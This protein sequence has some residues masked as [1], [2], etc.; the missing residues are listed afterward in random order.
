[1]ANISSSLYIL[2]ETFFTESSSNITRFPFRRFFLRQ[3]PVWASFMASM[4][5]KLQCYKKDSN[6]S[7][8]LAA[9]EFVIVFLGSAESPVT[10]ALHLF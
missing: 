8:V 10:P 2:L 3:A 4:R 7:A 5:H 1:M 9:R 6:Y